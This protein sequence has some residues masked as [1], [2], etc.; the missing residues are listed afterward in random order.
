MNI[1]R[2][3]SI[4]ETLPK[5]VR[6]VAVS[7]GKSIEDI[8]AL[9]EQGQ[10]IFGENRVQE[11][12]KKYELLPKEIKWHFVGHLQSNKVKYIAPFID[13][14]HAVDSFS[15]LKEINKQALKNNR[16]IPCLLQFHIAQEDTK[17]GFDYKSCETML[18]NPSFKTFKNIEIQGI[19]GMGTFT[20][21]TAQTHQEFQTLVSIFKKLKSTYFADD[22]SFKEISMGMTDDYLIAIEEGSTIVRIG[23]AIFGSR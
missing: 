22:A 23:S 13:L 16:I 19:M 5:N 10:Q 21:N 8:N 18:Q 11:I 17:Y 15:L 12:T 3:F 14:I 7:K 2:Y 6:L 20:E 9:Y 1:E 4:L